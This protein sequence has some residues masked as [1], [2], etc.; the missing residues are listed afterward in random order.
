MNKHWTEKSV[1]DYLFRIV[2]D[3]LAQLEDKM[4]SIPI[5]QDELAGKLGIT[6]GRVSQVL[7]RPGNITLATIIKFSRILGMKVSIVAYE[8]NDPENKKGP[9]DSEIFR[10]CWEKAGK[11]HDFWAMQDISKNKNAF[12]ANITYGRRIGDFETFFSSGRQTS[13]GNVAVCPTYFSIER[14]AANQ[15]ADNFERDKALPL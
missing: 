14:L 2:F 9:I 12:A 11:P 3:F 7:K 4:D 5:S 1:K 8:D 15:T 6:K 13:S 10:V